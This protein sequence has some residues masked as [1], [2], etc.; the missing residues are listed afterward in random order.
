M[1]GGTGL[2]SLVG[3][4]AAAGRASEAPQ[5][6]KSAVEKHIE[7]VEYLKKLPETAWV[8]TSCAEK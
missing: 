4:S 8:R 2:T 5:R 7:I 1:I 6:E 3:S